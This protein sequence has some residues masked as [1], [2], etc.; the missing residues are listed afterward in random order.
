[1]ILKYLNKNIIE[2]ATFFYF[3]ILLDSSQYLQNIQ[4]LFMKIYITDLFFNSN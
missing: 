3:S 4:L 2:F 1:M